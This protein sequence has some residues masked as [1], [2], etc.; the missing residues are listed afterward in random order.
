MICYARLGLYRKK[1]S[2][3]WYHQQ[4][5][6]TWSTSGTADHEFINIIKSPGGISRVYQTHI[7]Q[8]KKSSGHDLLSTHILKLTRNALKYPLTILLNK[9]LE[10]G[11]VPE[12]LKTA[13]VIPIFKSKDPDLFTNYRPIS[14]LPSI[15]KILEKFVHKRVYNYLNSQNLFFESQYGFRQ[16]HSTVY[17]I[18]ELTSNIYRNMDK[19]EQTV[20]VFL[21]LSKAFDTI[22]HNTLL[23]KLEFYG[24][25]GIGLDCL[26]LPCLGLRLGGGG[27]GHAERR[28]KSENA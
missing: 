19:G 17:A 3:L 10:S 6:Y 15:S 20:G 25:R 5:G 16:N 13:K 26:G 8:P 2:R 21:D 12:T 9:S 28:W 23:T 1:N 24:I 11:I 27:G 7:I 22:N 4:T 18:T 14:L